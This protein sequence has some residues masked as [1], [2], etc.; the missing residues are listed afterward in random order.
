MTCP[1]VKRAVHAR[2]KRA[3]VLDQAKGYY[4]RKK[5]SYRFAKEQVEH[6][7]V[8]A[9]RDR[10]NRKRTF[11]SLWIMRINAAAR[12]H[13]LS[14][15]RFMDGVKKAGIELDRKSLA[16]IAVSDPAGVRRRRRAGEG[17]A[18]VRSGLIESRQN[19][20]LRLVRKLLSARKHRVETGLFAVESEDLVEA[21]TAA[22][23]EPVE[24]LVAGENVLPEL[25]GEVST[26]GHAPRVIGVYRR[27]DLPVGIRDVVL[28]LWHV[29]DPGNVGTLAA[30]GRCL[31][32]GGVSVT[33]VRRPDRL[34]ARSAP[35]RERSSACRSWAGTRF[36]R[37]RS[38]SSRTVAIRSQSVELDPPLALLLG[39]EREG[40]PES[41][42]TDCRRRPFRP[43]AR[44]S[45]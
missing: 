15:N 3:K 7:L 4:G 12:E 13:D 18:R 40:L 28:A 24:L 16:D 27:A 17:R 37:A 21:A 19:E 1:R 33:R 42:V 44:P 29:G 14:Y 31:R 10:K 23:I 22:G 39:A 32:R 6:S 2:K 36:P 45:P 9:Y 35:L 5:S 41:L 25:L 30:H 20:K 11:R 34:R 38:R 26:L 43:R 8:Y